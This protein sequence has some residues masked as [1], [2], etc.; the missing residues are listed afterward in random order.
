ML[1]SNTLFHFTRTRERLIS[2]LKHT[3]QPNYC[4]E[5]APFPD[6]YGPF[7]NGIPMV[8]FCDIPLGAAACH[9]AS[10]GDYAI[11]LTK[12]WGI[13]KGVSPVL[14]THETS[15]I[16]S[17][18]REL[19]D[20]GTQAGRGPINELLWN[21]VYRIM[22][23]TKPYEGSILMDG[24]TR[25]VRFYDEREWRW[26]PQE[27]PEDLR[28][29]IDLTEFVNGRPPR[30]MTERLHAVARLS[31]RPEDIR[32]IIVSTEAELSPILD[33]ILRLKA[34]FST[35]E[36]RRLISRVITAEQIRGDF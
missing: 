33:Q 17:G 34:G 7:G 12:D 14:Y 9:M 31:F 10:Y 30:D 8:C 15:P 29:G 5:T 18:L 4:S 22:A 32:Y 24:E 3:F 16:S 11:G 19:M 25:H 13:S 20:Q 2:I 36:K 35:G 26:V 28:Y 23:F 27:L 1:S 21:E 6:E